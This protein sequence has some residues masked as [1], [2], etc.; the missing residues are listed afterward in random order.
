MFKGFINYK[1]EK[2][3]FVIDDYK[4]ELFTDDSILEEFINEYRYQKDYILKGLCFQHLTKRN[5]TMLVERTVGETCYLACFYI[6]QVGETEKE[7]DAISF[8]SYFLDSIFRYK[9]NFLDASRD[10]YNWAEGQ[11]EVY[12]IDFELAGK[13]H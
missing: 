8:Q 12:N 4:M 13:L 7:F 1:Q 5:I 10:G 11:K 9:Y 3:P 2:I 6:E